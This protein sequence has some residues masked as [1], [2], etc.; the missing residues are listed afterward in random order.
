MTGVSVIMGFY[1]TLQNFVISSHN[2]FNS[3]LVN[4]SH[5]SHQSC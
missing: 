1:W 3:S 2:M 5:T 4:S